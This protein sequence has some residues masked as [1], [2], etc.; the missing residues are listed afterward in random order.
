MATS[1]LAADSPE[2]C[3]RGLPNGRE[4]RRDLPEGGADAANS[5][6]LA[7]ICLPGTPGFPGGVV[8]RR[9]RP[10]ID[11]AAHAQPKSRVSASGNC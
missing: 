9:V 6:V 7:G 10:M 2:S 5:P 4:S 3:R 11:S 8:R 1:D